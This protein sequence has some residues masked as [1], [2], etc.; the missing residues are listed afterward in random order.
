[1]VFA[2]L[3]C[4]AQMVVCDAAKLG[5]WLDAPVW[6][7]IVIPSLQLAKVNA[8]LAGMLCGLRESRFGSSVGLRLIKSGTIDGVQRLVSPSRG[9]FF[10][11][12]VFQRFVRFVCN[13]P[14]GQSWARPGQVL[15]LFCGFGL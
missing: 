6:I 7:A 1:M 15:C 3:A 5:H 12:A 2:A 13:G 10:L 8:R 4:D 9:V 14:T 11:R